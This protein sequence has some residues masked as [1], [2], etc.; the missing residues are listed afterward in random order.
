MPNINI[1]FTDD[2]VLAPY[3]MCVLPRQRMP[4]HLNDKQSIIGQIDV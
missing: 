2:M 1:Y 4:Y 3:T